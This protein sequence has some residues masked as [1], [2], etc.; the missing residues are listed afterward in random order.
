METT[1]AT[2]TK[3]RF[4]FFEVGGAVRDDFLGLDSKDV[5]FT[6]VATGATGT[7][8]ETFTEMVAHLEGEGFR[9]F[10]QSPEFLTARAKVPAGHPLDGRTDVADFVLARQDGPSSDG[11]RP[12][13]VVPGT[14]A[15]DLAR[16]DFT[17]NAMAR[18]VEGSLVDPH[19]GRADLDAMALRFVGDPMERVREDGLRVL[20]AFRFMVTKGFTPTTDTLDVLTSVD[21]ATMLGRVSKER[22]REELDKMFRVDTLGTLGLLATLPAHTVA[23][24]FPDGLRLA[25]TMKG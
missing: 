7:A 21:A 19:G 18:T 9:V 6:V 8:E 24:M 13:F 11:R 4:T 1:A 22:V 2:T 10:T 15:D 16:R 25:P 23:A 5:D 17:V 3:T 14:L 12:D 20:R